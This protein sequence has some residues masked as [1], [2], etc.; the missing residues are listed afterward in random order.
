MN[1]QLVLNEEINQVQSSFEWISEMEMLADAG[2]M[3]GTIKSWIL[4]LVH[5]RD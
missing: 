1:H 3:V 2:K 4:R 5:G